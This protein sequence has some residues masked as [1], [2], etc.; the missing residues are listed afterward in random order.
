MTAPAQRRKAVMPRNPA[1][2]IIRIGRGIRGVRPVRSF[3]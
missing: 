2:T 1:V 3:F